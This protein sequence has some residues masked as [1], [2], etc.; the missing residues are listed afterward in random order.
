MKVKL[1]FDVE[2][3]STNGLQGTGIVR[4]CDVLLHL[5]MQR[6]D[7]DVYLAITTKAGDINKYL[8]AKGLDKYFADKIVYMPKLLSTTKNRKKRHLWRSKIQTFW[9]GLKYA[10]LL[11]KFDA[12][13]SPFSPI[14]PII[15]KSKLK[16]YF[17]VHD[18]IPIYFP[19]DCCEKFI[20]KF[21]DWINRSCPDAYFCVSEF[22]VK[23]LHRYKPETAKIPTHVIY[24][25]ADDKF[26]PCDDLNKI[27]DVKDKYH[28]KTEKYILAVSEITKRKNFVHL[29]QSFVQFIKNI[30]ATDV[31]LVLVGPL[32]SGYTEVANQIKDLENYQDKIVQTGYVDDDELPVLYSGATAFMYPSLYEGFGLPVLE[33]MQCGTPVICADNSSLPEVGGSAA[34]YVSGRDCQQTADALLK[35]YTQPKLASKMKQMSLKQA[36]KFS[37][38]KTAD[39]IADVINKNK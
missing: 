3:L 21:T 7:L 20:K 26:K 12:Y 29:L 24:L 33:A 31:S 30:N 22:T 17:I 1:L 25:G 28:I 18:L 10:K 15:Y 32:R 19:Q 2:Q 11:Q 16:T 4:V 6:S 39:I 14:S 27:A 23:D 34:M 13:L 37:W 9:Y 8:Q 35:I 5:F 38:Q 36:Q